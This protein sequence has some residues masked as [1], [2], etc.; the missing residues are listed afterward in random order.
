[1]GSYVWKPPSCPLFP[2]PQHGEYEVQINNRNSL[3][4][5]AVAE[6]SDGATWSANLA[7]VPQHIDLRT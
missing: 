2:L 3:E 1:M 4:K 5:S 6:P 7:E